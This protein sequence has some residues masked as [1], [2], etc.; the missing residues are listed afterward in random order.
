MIKIEINNGKMTIQLEV[1]NQSKSPENQAGPKMIMIP[2]LPP[3]EDSFFILWQ[4]IFDFREFKIK[5][6]LNV[7]ENNIK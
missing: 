1:Q 7:Q 2:F 3:S 6:I 5:F 4:I